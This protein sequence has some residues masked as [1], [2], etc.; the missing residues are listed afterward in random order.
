M[1]EPT[2]NNLDPAWL[3]SASKVSTGPPA[4]PLPP[5]QAAPRSHFYPPHAQRTYY[6]SP[7]SNPDVDAFSEEFDLRMR[8]SSGSQMRPQPNTGLQPASSTMPR[9]TSHSGGTGL[10]SGS[11][12]ATPTVPLNP[13]YPVPYEVLHRQRWRRRQQR[14]RP[15]VPKSALLRLPFTSTFRTVVQSSSE[16]PLYPFP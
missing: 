8:F 13:S 1:S 15:E 5:P 9:P 2:Y 14:Q 16:A 6:S 11:H 4:P 3:R 7:T 10:T 12:F